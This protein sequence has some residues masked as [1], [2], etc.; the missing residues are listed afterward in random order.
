MR[1]H[2]VIICTILDLYNG[3]QRNDYLYSLLGDDFVVPTQHTI[4]MGHG[5]W[6]AKYLAGI[7]DGTEVAE[8]RRVDV[9][10]NGVVVCSIFGEKG[11]F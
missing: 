3:I 7:P 5:E 9:V 2:I 10:V 11:G 6:E 8:W 1:T 4:V